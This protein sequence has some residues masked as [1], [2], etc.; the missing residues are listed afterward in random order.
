MKACISL[1]NYR[2]GG[3]L[4]N[5]GLLKE[6]LESSFGLKVTYLFP[7]RAQTI[8]RARANAYIGRS[9]FRKVFDIAALLLRLRRHV[10][11]DYVFLCLPSPAFVWLP[12]C[13]GLWPGRRLFLIY[14]S[15]AI[16]WR[17]LERQL[18]RKC[19]RILAPRLVLNSAVLAR[20]L[21]PLG[22]QVLYLNL[23]LAEIDVQTSPEKKFSLNLLPRLMGAGHVP[24]QAPASG[25][26]NVLYLGHELQIKG[27]DFL[28]RAAAGI[29]RRDI[30]LRIILSAESDFD[31]RAL[32]RQLGVTNLEIHKEVA[33]VA[34]AFAWAHYLILP[35]RSM[36]STTIFPTS[37]LEAHA[38]G[39]AVILPQ[40]PELR[41]MVDFSSPSVHTF[42]ANQE[43][44]LLSLLESLTIPS[45][46]QSIIAPAA[47][48]PDS[49]P[50]LLERP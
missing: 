20:I 34:A 49:R 13:F 26:L 33:D 8:D 10:R 18:L 30:S 43:A 12:L 38:Q 24:A 6:S 27:V 46:Y 3:Q 29:K 14:E 37:L 41:S 42:M 47:L 36:I 39:R 17:G 25:T 2:L 45:P 5:L 11:S 35:Y 48:A 21:A 32:A 31:A 22:Y 50:P 19:W 16:R 28:I 9:I 7:D 4:V 1:L 44:S 15:H 23:P 40:L